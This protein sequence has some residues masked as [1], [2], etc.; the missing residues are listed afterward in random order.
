MIQYDVAIE[1]G[2]EDGF[3][4][5]FFSYLNMKLNTNLVPLKDLEI[6]SAM[7]HLKESRK[8]WYK[9]G[10]LDGLYDGISIGT[11]DGTKILM[12]K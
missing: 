3:L 6:I 5:R 10:K 7:V 8:N 2:S 12:V 1:Y 4:L 11:E 9:Y